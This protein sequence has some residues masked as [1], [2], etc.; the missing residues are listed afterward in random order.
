MSP[1]KRQ[2]SFWLGDLSFFFAFLPTVLTRWALFW[3]NVAFS[4]RQRCFWSPHQK[5]MRSLRQGRERTWYNCCFDFNSFFNFWKMSKLKPRML[6][7][8]CLGKGSVGTNLA[9]AVQV[10]CPTVQVLAI[11]N[12]L[13]CF[14]FTQLA[15][16][17][18]LISIFKNE[19]IVAIFLNSVIFTLVFVIVTTGCQ[20]LKTK[21]SQM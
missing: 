10:I 15:L 16:D 18:A 1:M 13:S 8:G 20:L 14:F 4:L 6:H 2:S 3:S 21:S 9:T 5:W 11:N 12:Q 17:G 7:S 19:S